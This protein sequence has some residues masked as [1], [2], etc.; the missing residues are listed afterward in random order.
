MHVAF[1]NENTLGHSSY[2]T[3]YV[4][5]F[6]A[7]PE[8]GIVPHCI[9]AVPLPPRWARWADFSIRGLRRF[10]LDWHV[11]RWRLVTSLY[12]EH[13]LETLRENT[14]ISAA[15]V[16]TQSV[17]LSLTKAAQEL[18]LFVCLDATFRQL[19][20]SPWFAPNWLSRRMLPLTTGFLMAK[21][22]ELIRTAYQLAPWSQEVARS[23][24]VDYDVDPHRIELLPPAVEAQPAR[25]PRPSGRLPQI[26]F[27]GANFQRKGGPLALECFR[28]FF[29][30]KAHFHIVTHSEVAEEEGVSVHHDV[31]HRSRE[32]YD[33]WQQADLLVFPSSLETFGI[34]IIEALSFGVPVVSA[35][36]GAAREILGDRGGVV[37]ERTG[38]EELAS[39]IEEALAD[40]SAE[41]RSKDAR[42]VIEERYDLSRNSH[43]LARMLHG[44]V[45]SA[46]AA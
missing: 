6:R 35:D 14:P 39:A 11:A 46:A 17:G 10:G 9:D 43:R 33:L 1:I 45:S 15:V 2:L 38:V 22:R 19:A 26:L 18:P 13:A 44:A 16:N 27:V 20:G 8:L 4:S 21:E 31:R 36:V 42:A 30:G 12:V 37:L 32:W 29:R 41:E 5:Y 23:L 7:N 25:Q 28:R 24:I 40:R 3:P 34:V